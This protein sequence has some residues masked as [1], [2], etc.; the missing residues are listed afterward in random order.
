MPLAFANEM[1]GSERPELGLDGLQQ[2]V[3]DLVVACA[4][5][6]EQPGYVVVHRAGHLE[7]GQECRPSRPTKRSRPLKNSESP[8]S[9][10]RPRRCVAAASQVA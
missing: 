4:H 5:G 10:P 6:F 1:T 7:R 2:V 3:E 9:A 8:S